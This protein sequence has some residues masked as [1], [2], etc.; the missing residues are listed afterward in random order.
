[1]FTEWMNERQERVRTALVGEVHTNRLAIIYFLTHII[2]NSYMQ[3]L[4]PHMKIL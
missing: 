2:M 3:I 1:M 4:K